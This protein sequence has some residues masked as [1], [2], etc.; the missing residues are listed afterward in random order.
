MKVRDVFDLLV[1]G[2]LWGIAFLLI[3]VAVPEFGAVALIE[4]RMVLAA[5]ILVPL[6]LARRQFREI[7]ANWRPIA[8]MG[9]LHYAVPFILFAW[10]MHTLSGG[11]ASVINASSPLF[12]GLVAR[13]WTGERLGSGRV[14]GLAI[15]FTGV[16]L[17]LS[18]KLSLGDGPVILAIA[19]AVLASFCYGFAAVMARKHLAGVSPLAVAGGSMAFAA[20]ALLPVSFW[21][22]PATTPSV[23]SWGIAG[24]LGVASTALAF[25]LYFRLIASVGPAKAITVTFIVPLFAIV[26]GAAFLA[27]PVTAPMIAGGLVVILG[28]ALSTGLI[29][30]RA[31]LKPAAVTTVLLLSL[32]MHEDDVPED[33]HVAGGPASVAVHADGGCFGAGRS[34][35][36]TGIESAA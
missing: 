31:L 16:V 2:M 22:W 11:Y 14:A 13:A 10:A 32:A 17:L 1:L 28:T 27:E 7:A 6:V 36:S 9:I 33:I 8:L 5:A 19:A 12:A 34:A 4:V 21:L 15:G 24:V 3:R 25:V 35:C 26:F 29:T 30:P 20:L 18:E 23:T